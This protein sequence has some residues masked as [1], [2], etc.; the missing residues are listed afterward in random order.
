MNFVGNLVLNVAAVEHGPEGH[1]VFALIEPTFD[2]VLAFCEPFSEN[3]DHLKSFRVPSDWKSGY[4]TKHP[5]SPKDF[6]FFQKYSTKNCGN[7]AYSRISFGTLQEMF[8]DFF[9]LRINDPIVYTF[10]SQMASYYQPTY[11]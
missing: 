6:K 2:S 5:K 7:L 1:R 4:L 3:L 8:A 11:Q 10:K 9:E